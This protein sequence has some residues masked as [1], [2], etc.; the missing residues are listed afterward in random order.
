M[1][2]PVVYVSSTFSDLERHRAA[3]K[4][5]LERAGFDVECMEKYPAFDQRPLDKCLADVATCDYYVL[6]LAHRYGF[7]PVED[8][9]GEKSITHLEYDQAIA[10]GR[11]CLVFLVDENYAWLPKLVDH[12]RPGEKL[13][14]LR[15]LVEQGRGRALFTTPESLASEVLAALRA[16]ERSDRRH[17]ASAAAPSASFQWPQAWDFGPYLDDKREGFVGRRWL[18][19]EIGDWLANDGPRALLIKAD[20]GVGKSALLAE[21]VRR[22]PR[23]VVSA[24]H[25]CQHDTRETLHPATFVR[26]IAAQLAERIPGYREA[27]EGD[28]AARERLRNVLDDPPSAFDATILA[29]LRKIAPPDGPR[30]LI[31]DALD[32]GLELDTEIARRAGTIVRLLADKASRV[33]PWL[34]LLVTS[35][36]NP[37]VIAPLRQSFGLKE[38]DAES[39]ANREDLRGYVLGRCRRE[40]IAGRLNDSET[41]PETVAATLEEKSG[42]K[43]L[44]AVR[45]LGDL[46]RGTLAPADVATLP[47]GMD[48][49]YLD[50][51]ERRFAHGGNDYEPVRALLGVLAAAREPLPP[52]T[53]AAILGSDETG[54]KRALALLPDFLRVHEGRYSFDHFSLAEWLT[55]E[56]EQLIP[57]AGVWAVDLPA[58]RAL[59][60]K[61]AL[62]Q[63][64]AGRAHE[65]VYLLRHLGAHLGDA[66]RGEVFGRLLFDLRWLH[67]KLLAAG[68]DAL[69]ADGAELDGDDAIA[70]LVTA[71]R[72]SADVLR[73]E[74]A[75][76]PGQLCGRLLGRKEERTSLLC[77]AASRPPSVFLPALLPLRASLPLSR[78]LVA[79]LR[80]HVDGV[81]ALAVLADG[82]L[83]SGAGDGTVRVWDATGRSAP[84]VLAGHEGRVTALAVLPDGRLASGADDRTVRVWDATGR[85]APV[86]LAGHEGWVR[87]IGRAS[88]RERVST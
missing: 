79:T 19:S 27:I 50:A 70:D 20:F 87:E 88:C 2:K 86:V 34:R 43:F 72:N 18:F 1:S 58:S 74:V 23:D 6:V 42:G 46:E 33:P 36:N 85:S 29:P 62:R 11:P 4:R 38:I 84:V 41:A 76:L 78:L 57:R 17:D 28:E 12:G 65:E 60:R 5:A 10:S 7:E 32:E 53:L 8:N 31:V 35:R 63:V 69:V 71:L 59:T 61:W 37:D 64:E 21:L 56:N 80:G 15:Q 52:A 47:P 44:Y 66:D 45:T 48:G 16:A 51:F 54:A 14:Q 68:L 13:T 49:F 39:A 67:A 55:L 9:P 3:V 22:S 83:A 82:R 25:F 40:P 30:L 24:W 73:S 75:E 81:T 77:A 26:S